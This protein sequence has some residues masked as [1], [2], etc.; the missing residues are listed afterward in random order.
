MTDRLRS[1]ILATLAVASTACAGWVSEDDAGF[2]A[3]D[4]DAYGRPSVGFGYGT[5]PPLPDSIDDENVDDENV[6]DENVDDVVDEARIEHSE[7]IPR[8]GPACSWRIAPAP[9]PGI[10]HIRRTVRRHENDMRVCYNRALRHNPELQGRVTLRFLIG[11]DGTVIAAVVADSEVRDPTMTN[12]L[13]RA[14]KR[15]SFPASLDNRRPA[16]VSYPFYFSVPQRRVRS[17]T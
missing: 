15:W 1:C 7:R 4:P 6:D 11:P 8:V 2:G 9:G 3:E 10:H 13:A 16:V 14:I 5:T 17:P 12:C